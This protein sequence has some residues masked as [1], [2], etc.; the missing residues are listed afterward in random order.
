MADGGHAGAVAG[1][2]GH[3]IAFPVEA[4]G[5]GA[6]VFYGKHHLAALGLQ[7]EAEKPF[8]LVLLFRYADGVFQKVGQGEGEPFLHLGQVVG[9]IDASGDGD[10]GVSGLGDVNGK[11]RIDEGIQTEGMNGG[12]FQ[13]LVKGAE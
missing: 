3:G 11:H 9:E 10:A 5:F 13:M 4:D 1:L 2:I 12:F 6:V 7:G 8:V